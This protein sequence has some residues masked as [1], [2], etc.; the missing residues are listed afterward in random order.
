MWGAPRIHG[1][2]LALGFEIPEPTVSRYL[3][4]LKRIPEESKASQ[5]LAFL[6]NHRKVIAAFDFFTVPTLCFR[7]FYCFFAT[8]HGRR[9]IL[10]FNVRFHPTGDWIVQQLREAFPLPCPYRYVLFDHDAKFGN[11]VLKF[12]KSSDLMPLRSTVRSPWQNGVAERWVGSVHR[13]LRDQVIP[14][15]E[16]HLSLHVSILLTTAKTVLILASRRTLRTNEWSKAVLPHNPSRFQ[17]PSRRSSSSSPLVG[18]RTNLAHFD[19]PQLPRRT[20]QNVRLL[21]GVSLNT[22]RLCFSAEKDESRR[23]GRTSLLDPMMQS[24]SGKLSC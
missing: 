1:E 13:E 12:L 15:N 9:R 18:S 19:D 23:V 20:F 5:W 21:D 4:S 2:L 24:I 14:L 22:P 11:D 6:N 16:F 3:R 10:H 17:I 8:E 7:T